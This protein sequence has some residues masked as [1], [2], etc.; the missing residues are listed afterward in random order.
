[1][2]QWD[3]FMGY[4]E[5]RRE[6]KVLIQKWTLVTLKQFLADVSMYRVV[7]TLLCNGIMCPEPSRRKAKSLFR[8]SS[9]SPFW[10]PLGLF[11]EHLFDHI[12]SFFAPNP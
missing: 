3:V 11:S 8:G 5:H 2:F 10:Q 1:M 7:H 12:K 6:S 4:M 9:Q